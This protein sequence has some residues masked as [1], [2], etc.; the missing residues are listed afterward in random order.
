[1]VPSRCALLLCSAAAELA[2]MP[3]PSGAT[4]LCLTAVLP[5]TAPCTCYQAAPCCVDQVAAALSVA[6]GDKHTL[7]A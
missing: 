7:T 6:S 2:H 3:L 1:M 4:M 5:V